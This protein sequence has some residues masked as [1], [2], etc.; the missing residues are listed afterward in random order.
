[1][2]QL[3]KITTITVLQ[4]RHHFTNVYYKYGT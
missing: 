3:A 1:M 2:Q 4:H